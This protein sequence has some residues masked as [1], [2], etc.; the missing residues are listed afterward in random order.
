MQAKIIRMILS[1]AIALLAFGCSMA[2][3]YLENI[4]TENSNSP[5]SI[6]FNL[7]DDMILFESDRDGNT[8]IYVMHVDG[9]NQARLTYNDTQDIS[10]SWSPDGSSI[11]FSS[12]RDGNAEIYLMDADGSNQR[13]LTN[14]RAGDSS[15]SWSPD[16][17]RIIFNSDGAGNEEI[18]IM[19]ADGSN[20]AR[21]TY[22]VPW[23]ILPS[24]SPDG[25]KIVFN[26]DRRIA[27]HARRLV[28]TASGG[29]LF[30]SLIR[31]RY[32]QLQDPECL[33]GQEFPSVGR[34]LIWL[35]CH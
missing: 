27:Q 19:N 10:P 21:V 25:S 14:T 26:S 29:S 17:S 30:C 32:R 6:S 4:A 33:T 31:L 20:Q 35:C 34:R 7:N 5:S 11:A 16:G 1:S 2:C 15:P 8:E 3:S 13:R 24:W 12:D 28:S 22:S 9:S 23:D 18:Y